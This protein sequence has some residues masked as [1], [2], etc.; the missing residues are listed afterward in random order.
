MLLLRVRRTSK[1]VLA[2]TTQDAGALLEILAFEKGR[3]GKSLGS[4]RSGN[5]RLG[6]VLVMVAVAVA[7]VVVAVFS[8]HM[9]PWAMLLLLL[10]HLHPLL[11]HGLLLDTLDELGNRQAGLFGVFGDSSL[12][13][14]DLLRRRALAGQE[15]G[16]R[17]ALLMAV[18]RRRCHCDV[19]IGAW[20][21]GKEKLS[22]ELV[23]PV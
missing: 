23:L 21:G 8:V 18:G 22:G 17:S 2:L 11:L 14:C 10:H 13:L 9:A 15:H 20:E 4:G 19:E 12:N 16:Q 6:L 3:Y 7:V 1:H 5:D